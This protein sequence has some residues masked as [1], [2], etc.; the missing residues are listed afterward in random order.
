MDLDF[1]IERTILRIGN[2]LLSRRSDDLKL[3]DLT[4]SQSETLLFFDR[5]AGARV[6][7]L[8]AYLKISHQAARNI[9][10]R[11]KEKDLLYVTVSGADARAREVYLS[12]KGQAICRELK[13]K[14]GDVGSNLLSALTRAE[15]ETLAS[16]SKK[17]PKRFKAFLFLQIYNVLLKMRRSLCNAQKGIGK[18]VSRIFGGARIQRI[19]RGV[20]DGRGPRHVPDRGNPYTLSLILPNLSMGTW[21][22]IFNLA[23][24]LIQFA[25][26]GKS[27]TQ[28]AA[29]SGSRRHGAVWLR[30]RPVA[31]LPAGVPAGFLPAAARVAARGLL[32]HRMR[33]VPRSGRE[34]RDARGRRIRQRDCEADPPLLRRGPHG[35]GHQHDRDRRRAVPFVP[36]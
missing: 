14:G 32:H 13:K 27:A 8:K 16:C 22:I 20:R 23:L 36:A 12:E 21:V 35:V 31:L 18:A 30:H 7:D 19:R 9:V 33:R 1:S 5:Y 29:A 25:I 10:E 4:P 26:E 34:R 6:L 11:M 24:V 28:A 3:Y 17:F 2:Q 15:K